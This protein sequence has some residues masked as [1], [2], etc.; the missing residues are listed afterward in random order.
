[1]HQYLLQHILDLWKSELV[2]NCFFA[3][4]GHELGGHNRMRRL[5]ERTKKK[6][7]ADNVLEQGRKELV[8]LL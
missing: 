4:K 8:N 6:R 5:V 3:K 7:M 1:M 2:V